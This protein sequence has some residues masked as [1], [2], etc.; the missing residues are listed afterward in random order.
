[1]KIEIK[2]IAILVLSFL[3]VIQSVTIYRQSK[4]IEQQKRDLFRSAFTIKNEI[5][6][7]AKI[8]IIAEDKIYELE[9]VEVV[10]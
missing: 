8:R 6:S 9:F 2:T 7:G 5:D 10:K 3:I 1:M 4:E